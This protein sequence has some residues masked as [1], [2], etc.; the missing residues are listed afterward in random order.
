MSN[1]LKVKRETL[2]TRCEICHK[3]D[4][5]D[6]INNLCLRCSETFSENKIEKK[7]KT[8]VLATE[9]CKVFHPKEINLDNN[10]C[11]Y[12]SD[13]SLEAKKQD[14]SEV[15]PKDWLKQVKTNDG[16]LDSYEIFKLC[17]FTIFSIGLV[18]LFIGFAIYPAAIFFSILFLLALTTT[19]TNLFY[20]MKK[21]I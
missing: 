12:C 1:L 15:R 9:R 18:V 4:L 2:A 3:A 16:N 19:V 6:P 21:N 14:I 7:P 5:F 8:T 13:F 20:Y 17:L 11:S 10:I